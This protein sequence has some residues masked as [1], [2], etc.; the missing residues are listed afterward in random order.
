MKS[1]LQESEVT[2]PAETNRRS[3]LRTSAVLGAGMAAFAA[4]LK[5]LMQL[6]D[7]T[8]MEEFLQK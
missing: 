3:F 8:S 1:N 6:K 5:P 2:A 7:F 4:S